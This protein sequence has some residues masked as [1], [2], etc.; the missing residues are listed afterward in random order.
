MK[1]FSVNSRIKAVRKNKGLKQ[2]EFGKLIGLTQGGVSYIEHEGNT[3]A[4][5][6][7]T[8]ICQKFRVRREWLDTG[9]GEM[10]NDGEPVIFAEF[11]KEYELSLPEQQLTR[12]LVRL[13]H[14]EREQILNLLDHMCHAL[15]EGRRMEQEQDGQEIRQTERA[16]LHRQADEAMD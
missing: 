12:Y 2:A 5:Q 3:I 15:Q 16:E 11:A 7:I 10:F 4:E 1:N 9:E 6:N 8:I 14:T 13:S